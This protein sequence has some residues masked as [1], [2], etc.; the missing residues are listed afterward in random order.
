MI[1]V[2]GA[3]GNLGIAAINHLLTKVEPLNIAVLARDRAKAASFEEKGIDIRI[4]EYDD[5][6]SLE[7]AM[8][9]VDKVLL[10]SSNDHGKLLQQHKN[11]VDAA[12]KAGVNHLI[13]IG[14]AVQEFESSTLHTMLEPHFQTED[15][16]KESQI[17][18]T[19]LRN[20][21]YA[22]TLPMFLGENVFDTGIY[23]PA[24]NAEVPFALRREL[25]EAAANVILQPN[26]NNN[27]TYVLTGSEPYSFENLAEALSEIS[28][29]TV[30]YINADSK[31][32]EETLRGASVPEYAISVLSGYV[33]DMR[34]GRY[35]L[36]TND[37]E[38]ILGRKPL[39][40][41]EAL[42]EVYSK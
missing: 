42:K 23:L 18:Y 14:S 3:T 9:G 20:T 33:T 35:N 5:I 1:L 29:K 13:Y 37:L 17:P 8:Q 7:T 21:I 12:N 26:P 41:R 27:K 32:F 11:V 38:S 28:G 4:G 30:N 36:L 31:S 15:Y 22:D 6:N 25:G 34:E 16:I 10:I 2:T 24:G 19:I 39:S 40:L